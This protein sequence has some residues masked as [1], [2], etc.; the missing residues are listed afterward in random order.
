M[1]KRLQNYPEPT[2]VIN[3][4]GADALRMYIINS[5]VVRGEPLRFRET[6]V[7]GMVKDIILPLLNALK[8]FIENTNYCMAAGKT[9]SIAIHST[10]E[11]D[12]WMMASVQSL[13]RY[14]KSEMELYHLYNVV[15]GILRFIVD[16]SN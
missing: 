2:L 8:F 15:P 16:L 9:V 11:M 10:N 4:Y 7:K 13:V 3:E 1:S 5:P 6:G 14:V 12:R